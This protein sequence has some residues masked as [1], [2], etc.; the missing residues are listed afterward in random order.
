MADI[1][2]SRAQIAYLQRMTDEADLIKMRH[3]SLIPQG[4][5]HRRWEFGLSRERAGLYIQM[6]RSILSKCP[7]F[8]FRL[9]RTED[10]DDLPA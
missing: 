9:K 4:L 5:M 10:A 6:Y 8:L 3:P 1:L 2:A 7:S